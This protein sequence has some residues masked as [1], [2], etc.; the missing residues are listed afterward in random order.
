LRLPIPPAVVG[1]NHEAGFRET[2]Y[3]HVYTPKF[4]NIGQLAAELTLFVGVARGA[5]QLQPQGERK[6]WG[7][8]L[9]LWG[10]L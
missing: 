3:V 1:F 6:N 7:W 10:K 9:N 2:I 8:G 5:M 4:S